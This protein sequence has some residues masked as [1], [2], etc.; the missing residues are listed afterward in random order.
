MNYLIGDLLKDD[1]QSVASKDESLFDETVDYVSDVLLYDQLIIDWKNLPPMDQQVHGGKIANFLQA[2]NAVD[3]RRNPLMQRAKNLH[4]LRSEIKSQIDSNT[5]NQL[6]PIEEVNSNDSI[7]QLLENLENTSHIKE[8]YK[9]RKLTTGASK[10]AGINEDQ[11]RT[12]KNSMRQGRELFI[13]GQTGSLMIKPLVWFYSLTAY[14][15]AVIILNN[16][17]RYNLDTLPGSHGLNYLPTEIKIQFGGATKQGTFSELF[18][19][20]PI[21]RTQNAS[22]DF[23]QSNEHSILAFHSNKITTSCGTLLSM[24]PEIRDYFGILTK[25]PSRAHPLEVVPITEGRGIKWEFQIG[26][27]ARTPSV[28]DVNQAFAGFP[29]TERSGKIIFTVPPTEA[30]KLKALIYT[31]TR[32]RLWYIENPFFPILLPEICIH[33]LLMNV[34]SNIMRYRPGTWGEIL[35][36]EID[37]NLSL[38]IRRYFSTFETKVPLLLLRNLSKFMPYIDPDA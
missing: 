8:I 20:S 26:D 9:H 6:L 2:K 19:S 5:R 25:T 12:L 37:S 36:N 33:F 18:A 31:D 34:F 21:F 10:N 30:H 24:L 4:L 23:A 17:I 27:G 29:K 22:F 11:A 15:Y 28:N 14:A 7:L 32:G 3:P 38:L 13:A 16:P 1:F 35:L